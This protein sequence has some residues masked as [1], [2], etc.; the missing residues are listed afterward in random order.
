MD[1]ILLEKNA[2]YDQNGLTVLSNNNVIVPRDTN[3]NV[4]VDLTSSLLVIEAIGVNVLNESVL[5]L[6]DTQFNYFRF[7]VTTT[8][9]DTDVD[10]NVDIDLSELN[11]SADV[12]PE[13]LSIPTLLPLPSRYKP[14]EN[15]RIPVGSW[16][17][18]S[19]LDFSKVVEGPPQIQPNSLVV[20][21]KL[22]DQLKTLGEEN[23]GKT[24]K[25]EISGIIKT[26]FNKNNPNSGIGF[27]MGF[28]DS[29]RRAIMNSPA[30]DLK[31]VGSGFDRFNRT[32]KENTYTTNILFEAGVDE[33]YVDQEL[34]LRGWAEDDEDN[35]NHTILANDSYI[36]FKAI[37]V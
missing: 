34:Q 26:K 10:L 24:P 12:S 2:K 1:S 9:I 4:I 8:T 30:D 15:Q 35:K 11:V 5:P 23:P 7:P 16:G 37:V 36:Q 33:L 17:N 21:Q 13:I 29:S 32:R 25:L 31:T 6:V 18:P 27:S 19:V 28:S 14:S 20:T 3:G 22:L